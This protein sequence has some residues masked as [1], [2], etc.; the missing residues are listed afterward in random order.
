VL[1]WEWKNISNGYLSMFIWFSA[2]Y[3]FGHKIILVGQTVDTFLTLMS[4]SQKTISVSIKIK[5]SSCR[6][7]LIPTVP[8]RYPQKLVA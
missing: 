4:N 6:F 5:V 2:G 8:S 1:F 7:I 3:S